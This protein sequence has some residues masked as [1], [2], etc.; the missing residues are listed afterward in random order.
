[1][2]NIINKFKCF[3]SGHDLTCKAQE[4]I[5]ATQEQ[6]DGGLDGFMDYATTYC[7]RCGWVYKP[8]K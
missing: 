7:K 2:T 4:G 6:L 8:K 3:F 5:P 1:M